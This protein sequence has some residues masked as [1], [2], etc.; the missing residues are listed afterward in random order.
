MVLSGQTHRRHWNWRPAQ[1]G[2]SHSAFCPWCFCSWLAQE[3][4]L[5]HCKLSTKQRLPLCGDWASESQGWSPTLIQC[6]L[7]SPCSG[8]FS[9]KFLPPPRYAN[10]RASL[11]QK[12]TEFRLQFVLPFSDFLFYQQLPISCPSDLLGG[13]LPLKIWQIVRTKRGMRINFSWKKPSWV[14]FN[15]DF[16]KMIY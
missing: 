14:L 5:C 15:R 2:A 1:L 7:G 6:P 12:Q 8:S 16:I 11:S 9:C 10:I 3:F 4:S 13:G